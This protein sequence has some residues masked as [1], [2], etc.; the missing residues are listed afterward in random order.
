MS[1]LLPFPADDEDRPAQAAR[2]VK[3]LR[4][5]AERGVYFGTSSWK[6]E[7]WLGTVYSENRYTTRGKLSKKKFD[8]ECLTEYA[9]VFPA[10]CGDFAF[11]QFPT[12]DYWKKLF[13]SVP[14]SL[15]FAFK[16]PEDVTVAKW[17]K[18][19]R[20][21]S[22]AGEDN[23]HFLDVGMFRSLFARRLE[24]YADRVAALIFEFGTFPK[25]VFPTED[26]FLARLDPFLEALPKGFRY[27]VEIRNPEYLGEGYFS[28]L[29]RHNVAHILSSWTRMP[30]LG[31]QLERPGALS[32]DFTVVRALLARGQTYEKAV[33]A[34]EPY[35]LVQEPQPRVREALASV[36]RKSIERKKPAFLFVN[37]RLEGHAPSTIE[38]AADLIGE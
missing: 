17:P 38:A 3:K 4:K 8:S 23:P 37:N 19:A 28:V 18:H 27:S 6:Y 22:R 7:G 35:R 24:P 1:G 11:Y 13:E 31:D 34:F 9:E 32:A 14:A 21:G 10:V 12:P 16:V 30:D 5:L 2:L 20:Y 36:G 29:A 15:L 26:D 25:S 33:E